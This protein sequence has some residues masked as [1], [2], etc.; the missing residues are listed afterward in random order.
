MVWNI[1]SQEPTL[2]CPAWF[3]YGEKDEASESVWTVDEE[4][5][6][7]VDRTNFILRNKNNY[8]AKAAFRVAASSS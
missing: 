6:F 2:R 7:L 1:G 8:C 5:A 3:P 4:S